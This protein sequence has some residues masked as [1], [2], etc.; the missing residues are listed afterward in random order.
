MPADGPHFP[1]GHDHLDKWAGAMVSYELF[2]VMVH[3][4]VISQL[5]EYEGIPSATLDHPPNIREFDPVSGHA[6]ISRSPLLQARLKA[7]E[8]EKEPQVPGPVV[9]VVLPANYGLPQ[10][11]VAPPSAPVN[12]GLIPAHY[13]EGVTYRDNRRTISHG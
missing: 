12:A 10:L 4:Y 6:I 13:K 3:T 2:K 8:K 5:H 1:L 11:P 7:M 9:N